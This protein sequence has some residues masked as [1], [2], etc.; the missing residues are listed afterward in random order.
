MRPVLH[1]VSQQIG[2]EFIGAA[3]EPLESFLAHQAV[4]DAAAFERAVFFGQ[5]V[6]RDVKLVRPNLAAFRVNQALLLGHV[7]RVLVELIKRRQ[8]VAVNL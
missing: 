2:A 3:F 6:E 4:L 7:Q 5:A 8:R 1:G